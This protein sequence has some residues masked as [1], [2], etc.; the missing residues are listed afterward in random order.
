MKFLHGVIPLL[1]CNALVVLN[2][3]AIVGLC[4]F[5]KKGDLQ[6]M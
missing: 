2:L 6:E 5:L 4:A 1:F 3:A